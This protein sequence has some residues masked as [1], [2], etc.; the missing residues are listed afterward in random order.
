MSEGI[1]FIPMVPAQ[2][3]VLAALH[4]E[5]FDQPWPPEAF[6]SLLKNPAR[7]GMLALAGGA[8]AGFIMI[9]MTPDEG[10]V[11][12]FVVAR[13]N[14]R[15][16]IGEQLLEWAAETCARAGC[17]RILLEVSESN[18]AARALYGKAGFRKIGE[19]SGYYARRGEGVE[20][21]LLLARSVVS[22]ASTQ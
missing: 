17:A 4:A 16:G 12:T 15:Q 14:R 9:Q 20:T 1:A 19:R 6:T 22:P 18:E 8:P 21:A 5:G 10:E 7:S 3:Q 13:Q 11:L 2:A